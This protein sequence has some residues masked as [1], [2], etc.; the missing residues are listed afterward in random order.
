VAEVI[1]MASRTLPP[2]MLV[3]SRS[4]NSIAGSSSSPT[5]SAGT[6]TSASATAHPV[7]ARPCP[8]A[9]THTIDELPVLGDPRSGVYCSGQVCVDT[10]PGWRVSSQAGCPQHRDTR[11]EML[12]Q[13]RSQ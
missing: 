12:G 9:P 4:P 3:A 5:P 11:G 10:E 1:P 13:I 2:R 8:P 6:A 7:W